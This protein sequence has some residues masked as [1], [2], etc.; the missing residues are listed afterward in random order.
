MKNIVTL[1]AWLVIAA[2][3]LTSQA[4]QTAI[5]GV[6]AAKN[7]LTASIERMEKLLEDT[8]RSLEELD[9]IY[10][11]SEEY[12]VP[13]EVILA[14]M[15]VESNFSPTAKNG[16]CYGIM[17]IS[18]MHSEGFDV[19]TEELLDLR[20]NTEV[21]TSLLSGLM[22]SSESLTEA[23]G[24]YNMGERGYRNYCER[25]GKKTTQYTQ[26]ALEIVSGLKKEE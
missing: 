20:R 5:K 23:L 12:Q 1:A 26:K 3:V 18:D 15:K 6:E 16:R 17:Q 25:V 9:V 10:Q 4:A 19:T 7:E 8:N 2:I 14:V 24:K 11:L 22:S 13:P 21:G